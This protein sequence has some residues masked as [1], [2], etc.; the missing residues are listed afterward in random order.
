MNH[1]PMQFS[2]SLLHRLPEIKGK[3]ATEALFKCSFKRFHI[4]MQCLLVSFDNDLAGTGAVRC[5]YA[6]E[7]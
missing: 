1:V 2:Q 4:V 5:V 7:L 6:D 3:Y